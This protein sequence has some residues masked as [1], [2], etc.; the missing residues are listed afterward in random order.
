[1]IVIFGNSYIFIYE[2]KVIKKELLQKVSL[3][4]TKKVTFINKCMEVFGNP[5]K[6]VTATRWK[7]G[8]LCEVVIRYGTN[9]PVK[10]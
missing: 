1:M 10:Y 7:F 8:N 4:H 5:L 9:N 2:T 3:C 6:I